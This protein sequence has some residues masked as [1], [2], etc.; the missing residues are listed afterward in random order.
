MAELQQQLIRDDCFIPGFINEDEKDL[1]RICSVTADSQQ[2]DA[3]A[4][5]V[6]N[7]WTRNTDSQ[8]NCWISGPIGE[9]GET[10]T[11]SWK[12]EIEVR[13]IQLTFDPNLCLPIKITLSEKRK[14]QQQVGAPAALV[15]KYG[16]TLWKGGKAVYS[17]T[18]EN[19]YQRRNI[20]QIAP[21]VCDRI[22]VTVWETNGVSEARIFEI[23]V[24]G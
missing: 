12:Q 16:V 10:L 20:L 9:K 3:P 1:A 13:E 11:L 14:Q 18:V 22:T 5:R 6:I 23:R 15:K 4:S 2:L 7:G 8:T 19:N 21:T 24:Y 17:E